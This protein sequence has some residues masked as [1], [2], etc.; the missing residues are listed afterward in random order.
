MRDGFARNYLIPH[1]KA[2][3][4]TP[5]ER[6]RIE[7]RRVDLEK[8]QDE[9]LAP[10]AGTRGKAR[11]PEVQITQ[12][13]AW[14]GS[15]S[16]PSP[17]WIFRGVKAQGFEAPKSAIRMPQGPLKQVGDYPIKIALHTDVVV[18]HRFVLGEQ[19]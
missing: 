9:G 19:K 12:K 18:R 2:K 5:R 11:R 8:A 1:G 7:S 4:A 13:A 6:R 15:S 10:S 17:T 3:R 16:A 14:D